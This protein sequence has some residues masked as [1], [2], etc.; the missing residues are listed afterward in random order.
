MTASDQAVD[1]LGPAGEGAGEGE[2]ASDTSGRPSRRDLGGLRLTNVALIVVAG[3]IQLGGTT[4]AALHQ[5]PHR[6]L[7][8]WG[9]AL[10]ASGVAALVFRLRNPRTVLAFTFSATFAYVAFGYP[11]GPLYMGLLVAFGTAVWLGHRRA[12]LVSVAVG[13]VTLPW[14]DWALGRSP[15]PPIGAVVGL[16]AWLITLLSVIEVVRARRER[17]READRRRIEA[18]QRRAAD[19]RLRIARDVHDVVAHAMSLINIQAGVALHLGEDLPDQARQALTTIKQT[20]KDSLVELR[21]ILGVLRQVDEA[22]PLAPAPGLA[23]LDDLVTSAAAAGVMV[24]VDV[25]GDVNAIPRSVDLAAYRIIQE[26][27][28]NVVRHCDRHEALV[29]VGADDGRLLV[30][31]LDEGS[32]PPRVEPGAGGNGIVGMRERAAAVGGRLEAGPRPGRGFAVR[33][34]LPLEVST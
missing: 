30:E 21:A 11:N 8:V 16:L 9:Y 32:R 14:I 23:G 15:G 13:L 12:A 29:R 20:S 33:A 5:T 6:S 31:V 17:A 26:S 27:L 18:E 25:H 28:T 2:P 24:R 10:L 19:E 22:A 7:D 3:I 4:L 34:E 1:A